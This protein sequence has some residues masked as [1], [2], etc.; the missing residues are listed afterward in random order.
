MNMQTVAGATC[1]A[2]PTANGARCGAPAV[3]AHTLSNG[4]TFAECSEHALAS[5]RRASTPRDG[6]IAAG[7]RVRLTHAGIVKTGRVVSVGR[8]RV[9]IA[10]SDAGAIA[11]V[12]RSLSE[13]RKLPPFAP[14]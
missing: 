14:E 6:A 4:Q 2:G 3:V 1:M 7:T 13:I 10:L 5:A 8:D 9:R 11:I 12:V